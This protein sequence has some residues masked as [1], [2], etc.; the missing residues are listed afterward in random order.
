MTAPPHH[1]QIQSPGTP[2]YFLS[3]GSTQGGKFIPGS[4]NP[5]QALHPSWERRKETPQSPA[6][7]PPLGPQGA[8][9]L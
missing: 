8:D 3:L 2:L 1:Q 7:F 9:S 6:S 4:Q 5:A